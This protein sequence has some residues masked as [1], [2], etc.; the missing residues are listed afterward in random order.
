MQFHRLNSVVVI[1]LVLTLGVAYTAHAEDSV[2]ASA[3]VEK[4]TS[5][6]LMERKGQ[7]PPPKKEA[8]K[9]IR[10]EMRNDLKEI[11]TDSKAQF[12]DA[13]EDAKM[14]RKEMNASTTE[15]FKR[16]TKA[17]RADIKKKMEAKQFQVRKDA[18][19]KE[20]NLSLTNITE[21]GT[22]IETRLNK[23]V[24]EGRDMTD[25]K[26]QLLI[27]QDKLSKAKVEVAAFASLTA[28]STPLKTASSTSE[29]DLT[30]PRQV[31]DAAIKSVKDAREAFQKVVTLI[32]HV[33]GEKKVA[34]TT[35]PTPVSAT[36]NTQ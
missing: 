26:A 25:A 8:R 14:E 30:K 27:A 17:I 21:I 24:S 23:A 33:L 1:A 28:S 34:P 2:S 29:V 4:P 7:M 6:P 9:D 20:L 16:D 5:S 15:M 19:V 35:T 36:S 18:L 32:A 31:G 13:R 12:K 3:S 10:D 11:R 22:R